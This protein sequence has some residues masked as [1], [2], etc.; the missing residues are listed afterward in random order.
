MSGHERK[1]PIR[2][3][4]SCRE[5]SEKK[6]LVR[7]VRI[8]SG[9]VVIDPSG[10]MPGRGAYLC[11]AK[12]CTASAIKANKLGRALRC[13]IPERLKEELKKLGDYEKQRDDD[14]DTVYES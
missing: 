4:V 7:I 6:R 9:D 11:G 10:K 14:E 3:C 1:V 8:G 2:T 13:E 12:Q 5:S